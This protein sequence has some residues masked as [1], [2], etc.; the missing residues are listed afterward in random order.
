M[1]SARFRV[2]QMVGALGREG[3]RVREFAAPLGSYPPASRALRPAWAA[4]SLA[5]R[6]PGIASSYRADVTFLQREMLSTFATL[7]GL[8]HAPRVLDVDD[9][10]WLLRGGSFARRIAER[11]E[12]IVC[13]NG[14][15]AEWFGQ[16][17]P[18][19]HVIA[20]A[21]DTRQFCPAPTLPHA[22]VVL[23]WSGTSSGLPYVYAIEPALKTVMAARPAVRLRIV[24]NEP[25]AFRLL[26]PERVEF[27]RW[28]PENQVAV[29]Q[30]LHAGLMPIDDSAWSRGKCSF[31]MIT[32][33][34][35]GVPVVVSPYGM[36][37]EVLATGAVGFGV[38]SETE[39]V[40]ALLALVDEPDRARTMGREARRQ[41][42]AHYAIDVLA[43]RLASVL[44]SVAAGQG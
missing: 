35:C 42:E 27:V 28:T 25:P 12:A 1:P 2:R 38:A 33:M 31:K 8:T 4:A 39:W 21:V 32:Y 18:R 19:T 34:A 36:N 44:K 29:L 26:P 23:G 10:I 24:S 15:L 5:A 30:D 7:E 14:F 17:N 11:C 13:G 16:W 43:P 41:A 20:T 3:V 9:A 37:A 6:L 40:E 22:S